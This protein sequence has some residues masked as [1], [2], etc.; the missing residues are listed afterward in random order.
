M[1]KSLILNVLP[2]VSYDFAFGIKRVMT[3]YENDK[4]TAFKSCIQKFRVCFNYDQT[5]VD[6]L[7]M[8]TNSNTIN[9]IEQVT[10]FLGRKKL[11]QSK[12]L[13]D[14]NAKIRQSTI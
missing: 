8:I 4:V 10:Q 12:I 13:I 14:L 5:L 11:V 7:E 9:K 1:K 2:L 3:V 6:R